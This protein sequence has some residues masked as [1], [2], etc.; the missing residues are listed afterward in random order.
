M[1]ILNLH[2]DLVMWSAGSFVAGYITCWW[3][4]RINRRK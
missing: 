1:F 4:T 3:R 2:L